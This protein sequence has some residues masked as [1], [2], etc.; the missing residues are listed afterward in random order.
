MI[1]KHSSK[2]AMGHYTGLK[3][4]GQFRQ[5]VDDDV[6]QCHFVHE[7]EDKLTDDEYQWS[8]KIYLIYDIHRPNQFEQI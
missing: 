6:Q 8:E 4:L 5:Y 3:R 2:I 1:Q 7:Y